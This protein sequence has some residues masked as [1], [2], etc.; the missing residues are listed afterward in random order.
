[1][2]DSAPQL[3]LPDETGRRL[4]TRLENRLLERFIDRVDAAA[5]DDASVFKIAAVLCDIR[6]QDAA[7]EKNHVALFIARH[8]SAPRRRAPAE[9]DRSRRNAMD[10]DSAIRNPNS[11]MD[12]ETLARA[13][14]EIYGITDLPRCTTPR[15]TPNHEP[16]ERLEDKLAH[17]HTTAQHPHPNAQARSPSHPLSFRIPNSEIRI[18]SRPIENPTP[19]APAAIP[20]SDFRIP[21]SAAVRT[22]EMGLRC[23]ARRR[24]FGRPPGAECRWLRPALLD[25]S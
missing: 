14:R 15:A 7:A 10:P 8:K 25:T 6:K 21:L 18:S 23:R 20:Q 2:S 11:E 17:R 24:R 12:H 22:Q 16:T 13:V 1:M 19:I 4:R 3:S 9:T 5:P